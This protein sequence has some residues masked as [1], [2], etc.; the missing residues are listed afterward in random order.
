MLGIKGTMFN[1]SLIF[2]CSVSLVKLVKNNSYKELPWWS[3]RSFHWASSAGDM[4]SIPGWGTEILHAVQCS[5]KIN[6]IPLFRGRGEKVFLF[7]KA[8]LYCHIVQKYRRS[9]TIDTKKHF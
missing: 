8:V 1:K 2:S 3:S 5:Q 7:L 9:H 4:C 6:T